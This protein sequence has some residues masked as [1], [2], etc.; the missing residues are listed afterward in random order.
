MCAVL[1]VTVSGY[2]AW[3]GRPPSPRAWADAALLERIRRIHIVSQGTYGAPR[4]HAELIAEGTSIGR[5][6]IARPL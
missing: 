2:H 6:R 1:D 3:Q 5:K 4:I